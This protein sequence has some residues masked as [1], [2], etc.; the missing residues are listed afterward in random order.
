VLGGSLFALGAA[1]AQGGADPDVYCSVYLAGGTFF[2]SGGYTSVLLVVN[3]PR[4]AGPG[5]ALRTEPWRWFG[6]EPERIEWLSA[7]ILLIGTLVFAINIVDSFFEELS[8]AQEDRLVWSPDVIGC[9][10]FLISGHLAIIEIGHG[11]RAF[12]PHEL[13]WWIVVVTSSARCSS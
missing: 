10:L 12:R 9:A 1:L 5:G 6:R 11:R 3:R 8:A 4:E 2:C 7:A 13:E